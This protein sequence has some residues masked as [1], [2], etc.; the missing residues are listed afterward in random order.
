MKTGRQYQARF[1]AE[2]TAC[3]V[4]RAEF[5]SLI[6]LWPGASLFDL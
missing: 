6:A 1:A 5:G 3:V 4:E 2:N